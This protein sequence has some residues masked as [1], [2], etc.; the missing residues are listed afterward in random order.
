MSQPPAKYRPKIK[1]I[2]VSTSQP[3]PSLKTLGEGFKIGKSTRNASG[4]KFLRPTERAHIRDFAL[5]LQRYGHETDGDFLATADTLINSSENKIVKQKCAP[6]QRDEEEEE[7][8]AE[9]LRDGL[10]LLVENE[11]EDESLFQLCIKCCKTTLQN[12]IISSEKDLVGIVLFGTEKS[13]NANEFKHI[14]VYQELDQPG[15]PRILELEDMC[16]GKETDWNS[17]PS[18]QSVIPVS[19]AFLQFV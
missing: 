18:S 6:K 1:L 11:E 7:L 10:I 4:S 16:E 15:A 13:K 17:R 8:E 9:N 12:K 19:S 2:K 3:K 5:S 14:Y